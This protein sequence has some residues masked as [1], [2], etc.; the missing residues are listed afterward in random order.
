MFYLHTFRDNAIVNHVY[1][2]DACVSAV[3]AV[4]PD[5]V[6]CQAPSVQGF[7]GK[8]TGGPHGLLQ[9]IFRPRDQTHI[10]YIFALAAVGS[11]PLAPHGLP[12]IHNYTLIYVYTLI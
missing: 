11:V 12:I 3:A 6:A 1:V 9:S 4:M 2:C 5:S 10:S 8:N 7:L